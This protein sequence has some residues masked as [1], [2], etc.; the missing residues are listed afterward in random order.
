MD[1]TVIG[2]TVNLGARLCSAAEPGQILILRD[3][4]P[5]VRMKY[6]IGR[7]HMMSFKGFSNEK[8]VVEVLSE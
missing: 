5:M 2:A 8:E 6:Q 3:L 1:Y 4:I 7:S